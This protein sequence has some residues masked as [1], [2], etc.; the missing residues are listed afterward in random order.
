MATTTQRALALGLTALAGMLC[1]MVSAKTAAGDP[2][3]LAMLLLVVL[4]L[5][6]AERP[7]AAVVALLVLGGTLLPTHPMPFSVGGIRSDLV[8]LL[9]FLVIAAWILETLLRGLPRPRVLAP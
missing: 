5:A 2:L 4:L 9:A 8:E 3:P 7:H 1:W 6:I